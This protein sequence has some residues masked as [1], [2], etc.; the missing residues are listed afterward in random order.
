MEQGHP[1]I[2]AALPCY[3]FLTTPYFLQPFLVLLLADLFASTFPGQCRLYAFFLTRLQVKGVALN[4]FDDVF[5]LHLALKTAQSVFEGF[6]L[7]QSNLRQT[8]TPPN[9]SSGTHTFMTII[10]L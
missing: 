5:L 4:F 2:G 10:L 3:V 6:S 1:G 8:N 7:L 9:P